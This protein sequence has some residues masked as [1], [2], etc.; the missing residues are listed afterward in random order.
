[1][2]ENRNIYI[3]SLEAS[4]IYSYINRGQKLDNKYLGM[5]PFSLELLKLEKEGLEVNLIKNKDKY[6]TDNIINL[7]FEKK[8]KNEQ[9]VIK[10]VQDKIDKLDKVMAI[11]EYNE[12]AEQIK[13]MDS[14]KKKEYMLKN[15]T[16]TKRKS[17]NQHVY[18][19]SLEEYLSFIKADSVKNP[20]CWTE[21]KNTTEIKNPIPDKRDL[22]TMY[23]EDGFTLVKAGKDQ[24]IITDYVV[25]QRSSS[26]SRVGEVLFIK[27]ELKEVIQNWCR[28]FLTIPEDSNIDYPSLLCYEALVGSALESTL[29]IPVESILI[30]SDVKSVFTWKCNITKKDEKTGHL[31]SEIEEN[32]TLSNEL[33]D[34]EALLDA[35]YYKENESMYLLRNHM[36]KAAAFATHIQKYLKQYFYSINAPDIDYDTWTIPDMFGNSVLAKDI[37]LI[38]CPSSLKALKFSQLVGVKK[39][40]YNYW[41]KVIADDECVFGVVKHEK[42]SKRGVDQEGKVLQQMSYQMINSMPFDDGNI[43][44]ICKFEFDYIGKLKNDADVFIKYLSDNANAA[45]SNSM[46][47]DLYN[48]NKD[49]MYTPEFKRFRTSQISTYSKYV[50][51]GKPRLNGDYCILAGNILCLLDHAIGILPVKNGILDNNYKDKLID[52]EIYTT[53][54]P[55]YN[56]EYICFRN[57]HNSPSNVYIGINKQVKEI[58]DYFRL[59]KN[60]L[61]VNSIRNPINSIL[62]GMDYDSDSC[63][64][65]KSDTLLKAGYT[66]KQNY[67]PCDKDDDSIGLE[68]AKYKI[69][70][71]DMAKIDNKLALSKKLIGMD[72]NVAQLIFSKY[73]SDK[74]ADLDTINLLQYANVATVLS[75]IC[76]DL[77]KKL[78][79]IDLVG[80]IEY[81]RQQCGFAKKSCKPMFWKQK[82]KKKKNMTKEKFDSKFDWYECPM[83]YLTSRKIDNA[84]DNNKI[85][86]FVSLLKD[87]K[88]DSADRKQAELITNIAD[89]LCDMLDSVNAKY[90]DSESEEKDVEL[91][92]VIT[93]AVD[94]IKKK[95]VKPETMYRIIQSIFKQETIDIR[96]L[97]ALYTSQKDTFMSL[98]KEG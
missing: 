24:D 61:V 1:M 89:E 21:I 47:V 46:W 83:D 5:L 81:I 11:E 41:K 31:Y 55:F 97:N 50:K 45:N 49:I 37:K 77:A 28:M 20:E 58:D 16:R 38:F 92:D 13:D 85:V 14:N 67:Y 88:T 60:I 27:K 68:P 74:K 62:N 29:T 87:T 63:V 7:K 94:V 32:W 65:F 26:K 44:D 54:F 82:T 6:T 35:S 30:V 36:F 23:Y 98:F 52:N 3:K 84:E 78:Y 69:N 79:D 73:W 57:P 42:I 9:E 51:S 56:K 53:L 22:R 34:G 96:M 90:T 91:L 75:G 70:N 72:T 64:I 18:K 80:E 33:F 86:E 12:I 93:D 76:I 66:C 40:M 95:K 43:S 59:S 25:F 10:E 15:F 8:V 48:I 2:L 39:D 4:D 71:T 17:F 19:L